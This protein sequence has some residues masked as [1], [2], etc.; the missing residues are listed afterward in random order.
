SYFEFADALFAQYETPGYPSRDHYITAA[1][2]VGIETDSF[3]ACVDEGRYNDVIT[4]N[5]DLARAHRISSTPNFLVNN[6]KLEGAQP[7]S[8]FQQRIESFIN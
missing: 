7:F 8:V 6:S 3:L 1:E 4:S 5:I 2:S